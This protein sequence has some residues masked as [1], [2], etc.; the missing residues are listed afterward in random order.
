MYPCCAVLCLI[1]WLCP[2][3]CTPW[4]AARQALLSTEI[5]QARIVESVAMP[6]SRGPSQPRDWTQV[7]HIAGSFL[8]VRAPREALCIC[9]Y[10][11]SFCP[12]YLR[13]YSGL[14]FLH[15][16]PKSPLT[17]CFQ[18][19]L[20]DGVFFLW[21]LC[22]LPDR[23]VATEVREA[24]PELFLSRLWSDSLGQNLHTPVSFLICETDIHD[25]LY[26]AVGMSNC[27]KGYIKCLRQ[28]LTV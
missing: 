21:S 28:S 25:F 27:D 7:S 17:M 12:L 18:T 5:L 11:I 20:P 3:L 22:S 26:K 14:R 1:T 6:S 19:I 9:S 4:T 2:T 24:W 15:V 8:T 16:L 23:C 10:L 13:L